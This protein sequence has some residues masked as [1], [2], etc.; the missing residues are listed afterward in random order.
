M[1]DDNVFKKFKKHNGTLHLIG[2]TVWL[3]LLEETFDHAE[4]VKSLDLNDHESVDRIVNSSVVDIIKNNNSD[5]IL[6]NYY[7][8]K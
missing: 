2:D 8:R 7:L 4:G 6:G 5:L 3:D 1:K